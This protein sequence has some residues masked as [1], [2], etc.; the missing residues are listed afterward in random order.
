VPE[1]LIVERGGAALVLR[2][3][4]GNRFFG[5][6]VRTPGSG[7]PFLGPDKLKGRRAFARRPSEHG[8]RPDGSS[9]GDLK[10]ARPS[11]PERANPTS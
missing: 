3:Q 2:E 5:H 7:S 10:K 9:P 8:Q 1:L 6:G 11:S 4:V